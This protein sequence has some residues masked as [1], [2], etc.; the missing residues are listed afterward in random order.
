MAYLEASKRI[1]VK[2]KKP[3]PVQHL[4]TSK[5]NHTEQAAAVAAKLHNSTIK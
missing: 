1:Q 3:K 4:D 5:L 2:G